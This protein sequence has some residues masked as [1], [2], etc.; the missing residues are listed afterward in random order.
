MK[1]VKS[2]VWHGLRTDRNGDFSLQRISHDF[3]LPSLGRLSSYAPDRLELNKTW[4]SGAIF[5]DCGLLYLTA[6]SALFCSAFPLFPSNLR[7]LLSFNPENIKS[8]IEWLIIHFPVM[9]RNP[10]LQ[11]SS[12]SLSFLCFSYGLS[13]CLC[14]YI[15]SIPIILSIIFFPFS[16]LWL[17]WEWMHAGF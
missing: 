14:L 5:L 6:P 13:I 3:H 15:I 7:I 8:R 12:L 16:P 4:V 1:C 10:S 9:K 17:E 11:L 2:P